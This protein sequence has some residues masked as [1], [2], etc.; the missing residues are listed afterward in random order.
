M[1]VEDMDGSGYIGGVTDGVMKR[2]VQTE[3]GNGFAKITLI[4]SLST[5]H[6]HETSCYHVHSEKNGCY[7]EC[8]GQLYT[9]YGSHY[10]H[11]C[12]VCGETFSIWY[13]AEESATSGNNCNEHTLGKVK[14]KCAESTLKCQISTDKPIC[15]FP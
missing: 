11:K 3:D 1:V 12:R 13:L 6:T 2:D 8:G 7:G 9:P 15:G 4:S 14:G 5:A 10:I